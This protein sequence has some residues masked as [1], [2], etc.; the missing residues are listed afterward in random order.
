M[1]NFI[2]NHGHELCIAN[3]NNP[4]HDLSSAHIPRNCN[5]DNYAPQTDI[6][7]GQPSFVPCPHNHEIIQLY[8]DGVCW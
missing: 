4:L 2:D 8:D 5:V 7:V 6:N 1:V 3:I